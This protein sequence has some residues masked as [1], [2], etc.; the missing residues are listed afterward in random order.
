MP[1]SCR[2]G[3]GDPDRPDCTGTFLE[4]ASNGWTG[5]QWAEIRDIASYR[6]YMLRCVQALISSIFSI[7]GIFCRVEDM[8][9][10]LS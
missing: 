10:L 3:T 6:T 8:L 4:K 9:S 2:A 5:N 1:C 7:D